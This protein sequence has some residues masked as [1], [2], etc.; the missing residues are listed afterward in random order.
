MSH[1]FPL[2]LVRRGLSTG[3]M[4]IQ[5]TQTLD[6]LDGVDILLMHFFTQINDEQ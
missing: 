3:P 6:M 4:G 2:S 5:D 1:V